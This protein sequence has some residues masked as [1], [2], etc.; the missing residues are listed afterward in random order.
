MLFFGWS[1]VKLLIYILF[2][3]QE[4]MAEKLTEIELAGIQ[5]DET[6]PRTL[7]KDPSYN[8]LQVL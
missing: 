1:H 3:F 8:I 5:L 2:P 7:G 4:E 6:K